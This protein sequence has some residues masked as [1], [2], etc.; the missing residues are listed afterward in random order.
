MIFSIKPTPLESIGPAGVAGDPGAGKEEIASALTRHFGSMKAL[1]LLQPQ[2]SRSHRMKRQRSDGN[3]LGGRV[4]ALHRHFRRPA[5]LP[6]LS[7]RFF[8]PS[9]KI[10]F[11]NPFVLSSRGLALRLG[12]ANSSER[13]SSTRIIFVL[14]APCAL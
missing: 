2:G 1:S 7:T 5:S 12:K 11:T 9:P 3:N 4:P 10:Y 13:L 6:G 8:P 14:L